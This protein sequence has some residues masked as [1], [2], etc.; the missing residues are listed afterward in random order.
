[1]NSSFEDMK[2]LGSYSPVVGVWDTNQKYNITNCFFTNFSCSS[3]S[4]A[5]AAYYVMTNNNNFGYFNISGN[6]FIEIK[7]NKSVMNLNG[8]FSSLIFSSN[9]FYNVS[10]VYQGG[11]Y[12]FF[13]NYNYLFYI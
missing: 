10:S 4:K 8:S 7:T 13:I 1:V 11:V 6:T 9:S 2:S 5:G 12:L 3:S